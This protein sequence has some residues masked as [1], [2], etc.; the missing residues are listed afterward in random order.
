ME[1]GEFANAVP[2]TLAGRLYKGMGANSAFSTPV[3]ADRWRRILERARWAPSVHNTQ[4][5]VVRVRSEEAADLCYEPSRLLARTDEDGRFWTIGLGVFVEA[6]D[7]AAGAEGL[8]VECG[9]DGLR[10]DAGAQGP[11]HFATLRL[12]PRDEAASLDAALLRQRRT[13]RLPYDGRPVPGSITAELAG[14]AADAG[15]AAA[16]ES[17]SATVAWVNELNIQTLFYDLRYRPARE[18]IGLW[19]RRSNREAER[20]GDGF[21]PRCLGFNGFLLAQFFR[22][23]WLFDRPGIRDLILASYRRSYRGTATVGWLSGPQERPEDWF[24]AGRMLMRFWL[25]AA[26]EGL[27]IHPFGSVITNPMAHARLLER[28]AGIEPGHEAWLLFRMG[29]SETPPPS[30]RLPISEVLR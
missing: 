12:V 27:V 20:R 5:W 17:D 7:I 10:L 28:I 29:W 14:I 24:G 23:H 1:G 21:A 16:F 25:T 3:P 6:L 8:R 13:S 30:V 19:I 18:E 4:A 9:Y 22:R 11:Q 2:W 15:H 26:R